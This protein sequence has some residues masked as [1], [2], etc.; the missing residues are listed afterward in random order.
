MI[1]EIAGIGLMFNLQVWKCLAYFIDRLGQG[2]EVIDFIPWGRTPE[3]ALQLVLYYEFI[4]LSAT[5]GIGSDS[6][7][8]SGRHLEQE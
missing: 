5:V 7:L 1:L 3:E 2:L 6:H 8:W 4:H